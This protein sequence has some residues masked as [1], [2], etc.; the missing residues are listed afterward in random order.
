MPILQAGERAPEVKLKNDQGQD[1]ALAAHGDKP[2]VLFFYPKDDTPGCTIECKEFRDARPQFES[3]AHVF[4]ISP[5]D[6]ASHQAFRDKF[7]LNFPLL[8]DPGHKVAEQ[9]GV[10]GTRKN[11]SEGILRTTFI[12]REGK[13]A[14]VFQDVKPEGHAAEVLAAL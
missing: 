1:V 12:L 2:V 3:K 13:V 5:D 7:G 10:W 14:R 8:S 9:F 4:G 11:G 6:L